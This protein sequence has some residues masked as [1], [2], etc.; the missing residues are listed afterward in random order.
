MLDKNIRFITEHKEGNKVYYAEYYEDPF[1][2]TEIYISAID[3][4]TAEDILEKVADNIQTL[5][6]EEVKL[7]KTK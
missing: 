6:L 3:Y 7:D 4:E 2:T 1:N 5:T